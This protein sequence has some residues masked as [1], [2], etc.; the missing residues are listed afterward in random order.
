VAGT[1]IRVLGDDM[2]E[3]EDGTVGGIFISGSALARG[4]HGNPRAT[5][6]AFIPDPH[7]APGTRM[8]RTG[9]LA[10]RAGDDV[11]LLGRAD[12]QVKVRGHRVDLA[13]VESALGSC[14]GVDASIV[15]P[16]RAPDSAD[17]EQAGGLD[18][19]LVAAP[20]AALDY[21]EVLRAVAARLPATAVPSRFFVLTGLP[22]TW[23]GKIDRGKLG[24]LALPLVSEHAAT[25]P[26]SDE[27]ECV[28]S[29]F[30]EF[31]EVPDFSVEDDFFKQGGH[32]LMAMSI[33][34]SVLER[35]GLRLK[36]SGHLRTPDSAPAAGRR[37]D[38]RGHS[39]GWLE[40][41]AR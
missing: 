17:Q 37:S 29:V 8:Y 1:A 38:H 32:S 40:S 25:A 7:G 20:G 11:V 23:N 34:D 39:P 3:V 27:E 15:Q 16:T 36:I 4:Y 6:E 2:M 41:I 24:E 31:L 5:A 18:A 9:D 21:G 13:A 10:R 30:A 26:E 28:R 14:E 33:A 12:R 35:H 22:E 19:Y